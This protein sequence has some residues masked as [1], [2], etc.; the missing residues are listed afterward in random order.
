MTDAA[1][2][3]ETHSETGSGPYSG[4]VLAGGCSSRFGRDKALHVYRGK[5][6]LQWV[7][8]SLAGAGERLVIAERD[9]PDFGVP[10]R[11]DL[12]S[13]GSSLSGLHAALSYA[14]HDWVAL[15]ACDMPFLTPAYW[16]Q[17]W[18]RRGAAPLVVATNQAGGP[19]PLAA[20]YHRALLPLVTQKL[21]QGDL[22]MSALA[23]QAGAS[24]VSWRDLA[25]HVD[26]RLFL[27][28]NTP[29]QLP[30]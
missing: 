12:I 27:N 30:P 6:L 23:S 10:V 26:A 1:A 29:G 14:R 20:L 15:A 4:V 19:E 2:P 3:K 17:L 11:P 8:D 13:G 5:P 25:P 22:R 16:E 21:G 18:A 28:V 7:L 9:Y 24:V